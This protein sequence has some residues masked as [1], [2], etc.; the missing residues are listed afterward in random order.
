MLT[1][2][3]TCFDK[4]NCPSIILGQSLAN[5]VMLNI[6]LGYK[7]HSLMRTP[8]AACFDKIN[9]PSIILGQSLASG[10]LLTIN[11]SASPR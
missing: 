3:A 11:I 2:W 1:P 4:I 10:P 9:C 7:I 8:G 5:S 6:V